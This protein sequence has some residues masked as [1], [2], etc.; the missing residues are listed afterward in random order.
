MNFKFMAVQ[1]LG[2]LRIEADFSYN[3]TFFPQALLFC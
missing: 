2:D 3:T 1:K